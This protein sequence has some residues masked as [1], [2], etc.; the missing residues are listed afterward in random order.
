MRTLILFQ[1][2]LGAIPAQVHANVRKP[3]LN[4]VNFSHVVQLSSE[5]NGERENIHFK[6]TCNNGNPLLLAT[7]T[8]ETPFYLNLH[9]GDVGHTL[10]LG[11]TGSGKST[12][13][14]M[15]EA[16]FLR[17]PKSGVV[18]FD[19]DKS[20]LNLTRN[21]KGSFYELGVEEEEEGNVI[22]QPLK[23][24]TNEDVNW[25]VEWIKEILLVNNIVPEVKMVEEI[26]NTL[27][28]IQHTKNDNDKTMSYFYNLIQDETVKNVIQAYTKNGAYGSIFD[29]NED[30]IEE[31][32]W[33][34]FEMGEIMK[35]GEEVVIPAMSYLFHKVEQAFD[36]NPKLIVID[37]GWQVFKNKMFT[38][39]VMEWLRTL[40]K[41]NCSVI[42]A[43]Q[44][45]SQMDG[46]KGLIDTLINACMTTI[47]L[48]NPSALKI[49]DIY[50]KFGLNEEEIKLL[51]KLQMKKD[52]Y[53]KNVNGSRVF[54]LE[55][56][57][58]QLN[59][60]RG[61]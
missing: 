55:L 40:R 7:T 49:S 25:A 22:L 58:E 31:S 32:R 11:P 27:T 38:E 34:M 17:Y 35:R 56:D 6:K 23:I 46:I 4:T 26:R 59:I 10:I 61:E 24:K 44:E 37:E 29:G 1:S 60:I 57:A 45:I 42:F 54:N 36:G 20:A 19:K 51:T 41:K 39:K 43:T 13:L 47:Y 53:Y 5:W 50:Q 15:L 9:V 14:T 2:F 18:I 16:S 8:G 33:V 3:I 30:Y 28:N 48:P 21:V 12:L 52:Y